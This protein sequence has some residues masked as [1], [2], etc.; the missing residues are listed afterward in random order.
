MVRYERRNDWAA[1]SRI[2]DAEGLECAEGYAKSELA[3]EEGNV[4]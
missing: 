1:L 4:A 2:G 3:D